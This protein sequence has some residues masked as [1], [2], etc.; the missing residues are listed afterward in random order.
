[1]FLSSIRYQKFKQ[2]LIG[3]LNTRIDTIFFVFAEAKIY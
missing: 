2:K 1:M 3:T